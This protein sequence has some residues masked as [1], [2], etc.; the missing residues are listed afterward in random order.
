MTTGTVLLASVHPSTFPS[1]ASSVTSPS[2][3]NATGPPQSSGNSKSGPSTTAPVNIPGSGNGTGSQQSIAAPAF[4]SLTSSSLP[5]SA[6]APPFD[7]TS[8]NN[9]GPESSVQN[10]SLSHSGSYNNELSFHT[11]T[12]Y[13]GSY[14]SAFSSADSPWIQAASYPPQSWAGQAQHPPYQ[15][16]YQPFP[17]RGKDMEPILEPGELP[18]PRPQTSY[19]ALIGEALLMAPPPHQLYVSEISDSIKKRYPYYRQNPSK[20]Y[21]GVRHQTSMCKAFVKLP[22]PFGDQSGGARKWA[23]RA[24]CETWFHGGGYH[25]P[26]PASPALGNKKPMGGKAKATARAKQLVI[27]TG[28]PDR[29][30]YID[31]A[32]WSAGGPSNGPAY[33]G[34]SRP[35][36]PYAQPPAYPYH[37]AG[38]HYV[39]V[40]QP[41]PQHTN[42]PSS[43]N[44]AANNSSYPAH[45][46]NSGSHGRGAHPHAAHQPVYVPV[47]GP[48]GAQPPPSLSNSS[49]ATSAAPYWSRTTPQDISSPEHDQWRDERGGMAPSEHG[50]YDEKTAEMGHHSSP[51][52]I[53]SSPLRR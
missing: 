48:Y 25:P 1:S 17:P 15:I 7:T 44:N 35:L 14:E 18:A 43:D 52:S 4:S 6:P 49:T 46:V 41:G 47:W 42:M 11:T 29:K 9:S 34:T 2:I 16:I 21:N 27:G 40:Q 36:M 30:G 28:S 8:S 23:I 53:H 22:R 45:V 39:P 51:T 26:G 3:S 20:I 32:P 5:A 10:Q 37:A 31:P 38:Y 12:S 13:P 24:G 50:S 33:D 19:A